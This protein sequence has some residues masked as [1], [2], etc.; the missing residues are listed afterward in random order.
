M[1]L[2]TAKR[3]RLDFIPQRVR[4]TGSGAVLL[5]VGAVAAT[6]MAYAFDNLVAKRDQLQD[7]VDAI[8]RT[9]A[10]NKPTLPAA[11]EEGVKIQWELSVPWS[12]L[13]SQL[14]EAA[15]DQDDSVSLLSIEPDPS[16]RT[17]HIGA[18][19]R[20]LR[21]ALDFVERLQASPLLHNPMLES[22]DLNKTDP[23]HPYRIKVVAE[24]RT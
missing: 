21:N 17:V 22:H 24:W 2:I 3:I 12:E 11:G 6:A 9:Q 1:P 10:M 5:L 23:E 19:V 7:R 20:S 15:H 13:M 14:E 8:A 18:E 16:K 4:L